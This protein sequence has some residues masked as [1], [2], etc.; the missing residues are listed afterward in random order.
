MLK[1]LLVKTY[2]FEHGDEIAAVKASV[3]KVYTTLLVLTQK[4]MQND[5]SRLS[6]ALE[7]SCNEILKADKDIA[8]SGIMKLRSITL[9]F[10]NRL[11]ISFG[12]DVV[13]YVKESCSFETF[14]EKWLYSM[15]YLNNSTTRKENVVAILGMVQMAPAK[16][17]SKIFEDLMREVV[18][19]VFNYI[20]EQQGFKPNERPQVKN[21]MDSY[22]ERKESLLKNSIVDGINILTAFKDSI[23]TFESNLQA[24]NEK[25]APF[26][27]EGLQENLFK[28]MQA[29]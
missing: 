24:T 7:L 15:Q 11:L 27:N 3:M 17:I 8:V 21:R 1:N 22:S 26:K 14:L 2:E 4:S 9:P 6:P 23:K 25:L 5:L 28:L 12:K 16:M 29:S 18:P 10:F 20:D 13:N 19:V